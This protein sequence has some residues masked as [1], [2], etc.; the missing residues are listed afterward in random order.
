MLETVLHAIFPGP[1]AAGTDS[2]VRLLCNSQIL[3]VILKISES[4]YKA[5]VF[6]FEC[7]YILEVK[8]ARKSFISQM[9]NIIESSR[10]TIGT[11]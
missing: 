5:N 10:K 9:A 4:E 8:T 3:L 11:V 7:E 2:F 6:P 1:F